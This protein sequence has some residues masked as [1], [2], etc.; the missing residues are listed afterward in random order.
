MAA[1]G[2]S[3]VAVTS[4]GPVMVDYTPPI[5]AGASSTDVRI[6]KAVRHQILTLPLPY[7]GKFDDLEYSVQGGTVILSGSVTPV[8]GWTPHDA[9][10]AVKRVEGVSKV[11]NNVKVL[12]TSPLDQQAR[13]HVFR[14]LVNQ[15]PLAQYFWP[16]SPSIRIIVK[17]LNVTL[18]GYV[19]SEADKNLATIATENVGSV[20]Q[21]H[22]DLQIVR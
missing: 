14:A 11:V 10:N 8:N 16:I 2:T 15:G 4:N 6:A 18:K 13:E 1:N 7:Y 20:F 21:V 22:N 19:Q 17:N 3:S 5:P 9:M 12:P